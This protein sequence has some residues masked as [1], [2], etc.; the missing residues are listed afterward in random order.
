M[1][2][3]IQSV[4]DFKTN[5]ARSFV[6]KLGRFR[7]QALSHICK[8]TS[9]IVLLAFP[10]NPALLLQLVMLAYFSFGSI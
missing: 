10:V 2:V 3:G 5:A 9:I 4:C 7:V 6:Y 8:P 1:L